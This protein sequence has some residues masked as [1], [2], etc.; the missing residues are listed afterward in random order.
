MQNSEITTEFFYNCLYLFDAFLL[1][2]FRYLSMPQPFTQFGLVTFVF[3]FLGLLL[4]HGLKPADGCAS[5][6]VL[7]VLTFSLPYDAA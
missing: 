2:L 3:T 7:P 5:F 1:S 4:L 6:S